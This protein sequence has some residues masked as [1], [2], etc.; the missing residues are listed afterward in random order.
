[1]AAMGYETRLEQLTKRT[2]RIRLERP[3]FRESSRPTPLVPALWRA[4][5]CDA[6]PSRERRTS[7]PDPDHAR[8][9]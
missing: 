2:Y 1:M 6:A 3:A 9:G 7:S 5:P 4:L 8:R